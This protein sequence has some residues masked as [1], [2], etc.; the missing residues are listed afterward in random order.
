[1]FSKIT[2]VVE[3]LNFD[4]PK[5][6]HPGEFDNRRVY[7]SYI[8]SA[9]RKIEITTSGYQAREVGTTKFTNPSEKSTDKPY[10]DLLDSCW[11]LLE[12]L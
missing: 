7:R 1:M 12:T 8:D 5:L 10:S 6:F 3:F 4:K 11:I 9:G 2:D